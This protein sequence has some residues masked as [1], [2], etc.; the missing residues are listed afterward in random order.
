VNIIILTGDQLRHQYFRKRL[1]LDPNI[2]VLATYSESNNRLAE[3]VNG[4]PLAEEHLRVRQQS[5]EDF[6]QEFVT[7]SPDNSN[8]KQIEIGQINTQSLIDEIIALSPDLIISY[9]CS[10]V[11]GELIDVFQGRFLNLHLGLSPYYT[12]SGTNY[13]PFVNNEPEYCGVTF[14][15]IDA[16]IDTGEVIHQIQA[17]YGKTDHPVVIGNRLIIKMTRVCSELVNNYHNLQKIP[18]LKFKGRLYKNKDFSDE[19]VKVYYQLFSDSV[20]SLFD[21]KVIKKNEI[22]LMQQEFLEK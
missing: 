12:G 16:G 1:A 4:K 15:Y 10:I 19:S 13:W 21:N 5:E 8:S 17:D 7:Y 11:K 14:M 18:Q 22:T 20:K 6:F 3:V 9:G 2:N